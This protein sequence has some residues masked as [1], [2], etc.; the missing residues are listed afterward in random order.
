[1]G[2]AKPFYRL[3]RPLLNGMENDYDYVKDRRYAKD[4]LHLSRAYLNLEEKLKKIFDYIE[5]DE[6]NK[7]VFS[8]EL[9][10]LFL[11]ACTEV[12]L[13]CRQVLL[14]NGINKKD[15]HYT[16]KDYKKLEKMSKL[17]QYKF[18]FPNWRIKENEDVIIR[19]K[20][21]VPFD[22]IAEDYK[23][24]NIYDD[25][26]NWY[27]KYNK[28]K[29]DRETNFEFASL[30]NC[31]CAIA[32]VLAILYSQ[33]GIHCVET[34]G[35]SGIYINKCGEEPVFDANVIFDITEKPKWDDEDKYDF[36]W[37]K[38]IQDDNPFV[39]YPFT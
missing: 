26:L 12:E 39:N 17:S 33:F 5:P 11:S 3:Y 37:S 4:R 9:Y 31:F 7:A 29:H 2:I 23:G 1:M 18:E 34:Y 32:G 24:Q 22:W 20:K 30:E 28:V 13:N 19:A 36:S 25:N 21:I 35:T 8:F 10:N 15:K 27:Q 6:A 14:A 16:M 38:L